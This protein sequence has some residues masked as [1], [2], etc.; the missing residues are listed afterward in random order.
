MCTLLGVI[1][2]V[3]TREK[4]I[5][6]EEGPLEFGKGFKI[7]ES[8]WMHR[9][10]CSLVLP[11]EVRVSESTTDMFILQLAHYSSLMPSKRYS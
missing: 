6:K 3:G 4:G 9:R 7:R 11:R 1:D 8:L 10:L 5:V 2:R